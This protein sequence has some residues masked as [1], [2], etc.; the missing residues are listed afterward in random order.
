[1]AYTEAQRKEIALRARQWDN[2]S[3]VAEFYGISRNM[4]YKVLEEFG[5]EFSEDELLE[6]EL[7]GYIE[8]AQQSLDRMEQMGSL[9]ERKRYISSVL[10]ELILRMI[11]HLNDMETF[12]EVHPKDLAKMVKDLEAVRAKLSGE[13]TVIIEERLRIKKMVLVAMQQEFGDEAA[14]RLVDKLERMEG[15]ELGES[16]G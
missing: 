8:R 11:D 3:K 1:M 5:D 2:K 10:E 7:G 4:V 12:L 6:P 9:A 16:E 13:P 15:N 14:A